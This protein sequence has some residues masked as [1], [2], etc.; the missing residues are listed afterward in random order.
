M[1][2]DATKATH[3]AQRELFK[4]CVLGVN[5]RMEARSLARRIGQP[6]IV[7]RDLLR[8]HRRPTAGFGNGPTPPLI[9]PCWSD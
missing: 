4:Q 8:A 7:A 1:P 3:A 6:E 9:R 5:Y 2:P